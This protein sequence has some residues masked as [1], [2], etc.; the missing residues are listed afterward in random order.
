LLFIGSMSW[1]P[2]TVGKRGK[3]P[4][5][6]T[7]REIQRALRAAKA[8]KE[9]RTIRI[10]RDGSIELVPIDGADRELPRVPPNPWE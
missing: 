1:E 6:F 8:E 4:Q 2:S 9:H 5:I 10:T 7:Q 3:R